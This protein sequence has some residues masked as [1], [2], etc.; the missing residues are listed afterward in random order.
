MAQKS[1]ELCLRILLVTAQLHL[2]RARQSMCL[3]L[4]VFS[5]CGGIRTGIAMP[6]FEFDSPHS[7]AVLGHREKGWIVRGM[8]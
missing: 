2:K 3:F 8:N 6:V 1:R 4:V 7:R 5:A